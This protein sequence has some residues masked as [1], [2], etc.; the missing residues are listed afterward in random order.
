VIVPDLSVFHSIIQ[1][2]NN[3]IA[4]GDNEIRLAGQGVGRQLLRLW[5][6]TF[7]GTVP[8]ALPVNAT[9]YGQCGWRFGSN[10]TPEVFT[11]GRHL[12]YFNERM[13]GADIASQEGFGLLD[14]ASEHAFRDSIDEGAAT[15]L[16]LLVNIPA[17]VSL[18]S[19]FLEYTQETVFAGAVGA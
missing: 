4:N 16:R 15:E 17:G 1:T 8:V 9:N 12:A 18:T 5:W 13:L 7:S 10:D 3:S 14:W 19:P 2:R 6:R 11:D